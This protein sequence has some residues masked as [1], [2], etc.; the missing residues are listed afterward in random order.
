MGRSKRS[1]REGQPLP[2]CCPAKK[3]EA[4]Q[5]GQVHSLLAVQAMPIINARVEGEK[6]SF[7]CSSVSPALS[8][9]LHVAQKWGAL[10]TTSTQM[11]CTGLASLRKK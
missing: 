4:F 10:R 9:K 11:A 3:T 7:S 8:D 2:V 5:P 1:S 6:E